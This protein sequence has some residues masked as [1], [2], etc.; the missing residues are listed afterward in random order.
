MAAPASRE[1]SSELIKR[2]QVLEVEIAN[3]RQ[4]ANSSDAK[5]RA[6]QEAVDREQRAAKVRFKNKKIKK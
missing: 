2:C 1:D 3:A 5:A 6:L 4:S